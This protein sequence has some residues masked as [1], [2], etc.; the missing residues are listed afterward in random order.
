M[1]TQTRTLGWVILSVAVCA[2]TLA[3]PCRTDD[4]LAALEARHFAE[5]R[6]AAEPCAATDARSALLTGRAYLAERNIE[7]AVASLEK[8]A[9]LDPK[10]SD[11]ELWLGRAYGQKAMQASVFSRASLAGKVHKAFERAVELDP[12]NADARLSLMEFY[13]QAPGIMGGSEEKARDQAA[14]IR[15]SDAFKGYQAFGR[16]AEHGKKWD[17]ALAE[18]EHAAREFPKRREPAVWRANVAAQQKDYAR[19][20][21]ILE[22]FLKAEPAQESVCFTIGRLGAQSG[23]RMDRAEECLKRYLAHEPAKDEPPL[24]AAHYQLGLLYDRKGNRDLARTE[25]QK[26]LALEPGHPGARE[27]LAK[28]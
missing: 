8:A 11:A 26:A 27:A 2:P 25:Y 10:S 28:K 6:A 12:S 1:T 24:S 22:A 23:E 18:Y 19:A 9:A 16:I 7:P 15:Q 20:F 5:A 13:L 21:D 3:G 14:K 17:A 4:A